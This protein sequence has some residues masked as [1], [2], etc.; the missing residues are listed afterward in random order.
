MAHDAGPVGRKRPHRSKA[1]HLTVVPA[2]GVDRV[3]M[4]RI[5]SLL[6]VGRRPVPIGNARSLT[7][8]EL[9]LR[10]RLVTFDCAQ[11]L[12]EVRWNPSQLALDSARAVGVYVD[13][14]QALAEYQRLLSSR[15]PLFRELNLTRSREVCDAFWLRLTEDWATASGIAPGRVGDIYEEA[16][17]R[18]FGPDSEVFRLYDDVI[19]TLDALRDKGI[20]MAIISNWDVSL[21]R[22]V[23]MLG[24]SPYFE[25]VIASLEEGV[26]KPEPEI[27]HLALRKLAASPDVSLHVGDQPVDDLQGARQV[28]MRG[29]LIDRTQPVSGRLVLNRLDH[30]LNHL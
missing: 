4:G 15:W 11:T 27:F 5:R 26:E 23:E 19:P 10:T 20:R 12:V 25:L 9:A 30:I 1:E 29:L 13:K 8:E 21:H 16:E 24:L 17:R 7:K 14:V 22:V 18:L 6:Y 2:R 3:W 28:G